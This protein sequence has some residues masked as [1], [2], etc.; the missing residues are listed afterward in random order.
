MCL[1]FAIQWSRTVELVFVMERF[2]SCI[3]FALGW[4]MWITKR[5]NGWCWRFGGG[6]R[7]LQQILYNGVFWSSWRQIDKKKL[8]VHLDCLKIGE[9]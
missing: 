8:S 3:T 2:H 7:W 5:S 4:G 1:M 6:M 9:A